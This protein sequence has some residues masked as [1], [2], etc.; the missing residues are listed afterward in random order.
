[1]PITV[2]RAYIET[3]ESNVRQLAQQR[4]TRL[5]QFVTAVNKQSES[6]NWDRLAASSARKKTSPRMESPAGGNGSGAVGS[7]DGL[8]WTRRKTVVETY[9]TGEIIEPENLVQTLIDPKSASTVNLAMNMARQV[10]DIIIAAATGDALDGDNN[11][12]AFPASQKIGDAT[13]LLTLDTILAVDELYA[14]NDVDPDE[15]KVMVIGP[16]QKR[17]LM[18]LLEVT[19]GD[20]QNQKALATGMLPDWM[21][22]TWVVSNR[23]LSPAGD[24]SDI[25]CL[26]FTPKGLGLHVARDITAK[27]GERT[28]MSFAIQLYCMMT[29]DAVRTEDEHV[30]HLHL[31]NALA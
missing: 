7:T 28:D 10:D 20:F 5:R 31:K 4:T 6:H 13:T 11:A 2:D 27:V 21:G 29:M 1:M 15:P 9:D 17:A 30:V 14:K 18:Q 24:G 22:Y 23:L 8:E 25:S 3:F 26:S 16:T 19:S 12:V